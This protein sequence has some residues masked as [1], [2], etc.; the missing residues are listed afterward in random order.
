[1]TK[2]ALNEDI[3]PGMARGAVW[4]DIIAFAFC[5]ACSRKS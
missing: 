3:K 1:M 5:H 2:G 4:Y